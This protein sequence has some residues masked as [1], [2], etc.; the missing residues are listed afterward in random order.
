MPHIQITL[1]EGR[2]PEQKRKIV[3]RIT[4]TMIEEAGTTLEAVSVAF[5]EVAP[6][7]FARAGVLM[8]DRQ[9]T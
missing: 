6:A 4:A 3:Q 8:L 7:D 5:V 1:L 9:K 2:T